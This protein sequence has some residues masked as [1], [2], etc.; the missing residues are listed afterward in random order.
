M[1]ERIINESAVREHA[2]NC[3]NE[4][5]AGRFERVGRE[6]IDEVEAD[7]EA[8]IR[9]INGKYQPAI[10]AVVDSADALMVSGRYMEKMRSAIDKAVARL[11]QSKVQRHPSVGKTLVNTR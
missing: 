9:E 8:L 7:V 2:L 10:H 1:S 4:I 3:S 5:R 6:F 11:I